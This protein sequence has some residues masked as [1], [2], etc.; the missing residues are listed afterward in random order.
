MK[1]STKIWLFVATAFVLI[2]AVAF[3]AVM[4]V[5]QWSFDI[6]GKRDYQYHSYDVWGPFNDIVI[7][8]D[9]ADIT[10]SSFAVDSTGLLDDQPSNVQIYDDPK[11]EYEV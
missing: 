7:Y 1:T 6:F 10:F 9:T 8:S 2:G 4:A 5:N 3:V 11:V